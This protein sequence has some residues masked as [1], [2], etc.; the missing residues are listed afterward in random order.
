[1]EIVTADKIDWCWEQLT[2]GNK[3]SVRYV[4]DIK[5]SAENADFMVKE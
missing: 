2:S 1:V 4:I 3:D 5:K